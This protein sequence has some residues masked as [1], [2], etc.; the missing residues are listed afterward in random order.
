METMVNNINRTIS[1][2]RA[3]DSFIFHNDIQKVFKETRKLYYS[4]YI[5]QI[6]RLL[7]KD[8]LW[9][10]EKDGEIIGVCGWIL[11]NKE[12]EFQ[13]NKLTWILPGN[14][15]EGN[16]IYISFCLIT[17]GNIHGFRSEFRRL[18]SD[19]VDEVF[20]YDIAKHKYIRRKNILKEMCH[21]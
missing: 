13:I 21:V 17:K 11:I 1:R 5:R 8:Q 9:I 4:N 20:W 3:V 14:I 16:I 19:K 2:C 18:F 12:D 15:N 10:Q 7:D 6:E